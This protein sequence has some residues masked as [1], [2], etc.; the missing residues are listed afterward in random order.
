M[1]ASS[2]SARIFAPAVLVAGLGAGMAGC[3]SDGTAASAGTTSDATSAATPDTS[4]ATDGQFQTH[5][6]PT[7][8]VVPAAEALRLYWNDG[9]NLFAAVRSAT[10]HDTEPQGSSSTVRYD[11]VVVPQ[12][13][14]QWA[15]EFFDHDLITEKRG[16]SEVR[17]GKPQMSLDLTVARTKD[18]AA[19]EKLF[20]EL[21]AVVLSLPGTEPRGQLEPFWVSVGIRNRPNRRTIVLQMPNEPEDD[22]GTYV[23]SLR[24]GFNEDDPSWDGGQ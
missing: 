9:P 2:I 22:Q 11:V 13:S 8:K 19:A 17:D 10:P 24:V 3:S 23:I 14:P 18:R 1:T 4:A 16:S 20:T 15:G 5:A 7:Y 21:K 6:R 12:G